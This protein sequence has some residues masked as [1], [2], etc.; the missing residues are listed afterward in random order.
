MFLFSL[1]LVTAVAADNQYKPYLHEASVPEH[2]KVKLYGSY[3]TNLFPGA[4]TYDY[5]IELPSGTGGLAPRLSLSYNSQTVAQRPGVM[6]AGWKLSQD[7]VY[8]DI[9]STPADPSDDSYKLAVGG[10]TYDLVFVPSDGFYHTKV[11]SFVRVEMPTGAGNTYGA[12]WLVTMRDGTKYRFG[13][14]NDSETVSNTGRGYAL[15]WSLDQVED[16]HGNRIFYTYL[17]DPNPEDAGSSYLSRI[18]YNNDRARSIRFDYEPLPRPDLR[19]AYESGNLVTESR[20]LTGISVFANNGLV[21]RYAIDYAALNPEGSLTSVS[22]ISY[23]G[24]DGASMLGKASFDYYQSAPG[25]TLQASQWTSPTSFAFE[26]ND[27]GVRYVDL[28]RDGFVDVVEYRQRTGE[29]KVWLNDGRGGWTDGTSVWALPVFTSAYDPS[30]SKSYY[31]YTQFASIEPGDYGGLLW[32][33]CPTTYGGDTVDNCDIIQYSGDYPTSTTIAPGESWVKCYPGDLS[34]ILYSMCCNGTSMISPSSHDAF[35]CCYGK[36]T[37]MDNGYP[38]CNG[39]TNHL[40]PYVSGTF[41]V[42]KTFFKAVYKMVDIDNGVRFADLNNDGLPDMLQSIDGTHRAWL[43][44]GSGWTEAPGQWAP[45]V[46][47]FSSYKDQG[48]QLTDLNGD[49]RVDIIQATDDAS[50]NPTRR[51]WLNTGSGWVDASATWAAPAA[52]VR[53]GKDGGARLEDVNGDGLPDILLSNGTGT[54]AWL[55]TGSGWVDAPTWYPPSASTFITSSS[56]DGGVRFADVNG[57]GL[58]DMLEDY[59]NGT[60]TDRGA[61]INSGHGWTLDPAWQS[62]EPFTKDGKNIGRRLADIDG[63]GQAD[64]SVAYSNSTGSYTW[65]WLRDQQTPFMLMRVTNMLGGTTQVGYSPSTSFPNYGADGLSD[66]GFNVWVVGNATSDNSVPGGFHVSSQTAYA[67][68]DGLYDYKDF[69]F[70]G[71]G[72]V[73]ENL[74]DGSY[75]VHYFHQ[76]DERKGI[77]YRTELSD[78]A[79]AL[80]SRSESEFDV[81]KMKGL[82][83]RPDPEPPKGTSIRYSADQTV[84]GNMAEYDNVTCDA[85]VTLTVCPYDGTAGTGYWNVSARYV[86]LSC[87]I[88][89]A[90]KGYTG[91]AGVTVGTG[92]NGLGQANG[93]GKG[94]GGQ[95]SYRG[96]GGGGGAYGGSGGTGDVESAR[97]GG[98]AGGTSFSSATA[99]QAV[100]MGSGGG[101]GGGGGTGCGGGAGG[102]G[103]AMLEI[104]APAGFVK[105]SGTINLNGADG[106]GGNGYSA[107]CLGWGGSGGAGSGGGLLLFSKTLDMDGAVITLSGGDSVGVANGGDPNGWGHAGGSGGGGRAYFIYTTLA[108]NASSINVNSGYSTGPQSLGSAG[109]AYFEENGPVWTD[110]PYS[111]PIETGVYEVL[112]SSRTDY[113]FDG[114]ADGPVTTKA[115]YSYD[116]YGNVVERR[117]LGDVSVAGDEKTERYSYATN[118]SAWIVNLPAEYQLL[119][120]DGTKAKGMSYAYDGL[121][122]GGGVAKGDLTQTKAWLDTAADESQNPVTSYA[123]DS[124]GNMVSSTDPLGRTTTYSYGE[125]DA[126]YTYPDSATNALGQ[127]TESAY[128]FGTGNLLWTKFSG[129]NRTYEYDVFGRVL[130]EVLPPNTDAAPTKFYSYSFDGSA[131]ELVKV[132]VVLPDGMPFEN[133]YFYDGF[134]T[135]V[136]VR[137]PANGGQQDV[138][139]VFYDGLGR[140]AKMQNPYFEAASAEL[141]APQTDVTYAYYTSYTY[142]PL[143]RAVKVTGPDATTRNVTF[144]RNTV[145]DYDQNGHRHTYVLDGYGRIAKVVEYNDDPLAG[146][147]GESESYETTY[148]YDTADN[149]VKIVDSASSTYAFAYDSLG[150]KI[151]TTDPDIGIVNY[152]YDLAGNLVSQAQAGGGSLVSGDGLYREYD[153]LNQLVRIRSGTTASSPLLENYTYDPYGSRVKIERNDSAKTKIY[154]PFREF[155]RIVNTTSTYDYTY[156]YQGD[157]LIARVNPDGSKYYYQSDSLGSTSLVTDDSGVVIENTFYSPYGEVLS[158]GKSDV[159]LYT[160]Q[161][162]DSASQYY[163]GARYYSPAVSQFTQPDTTVS[164]IY[165]PQSINPYSYAL[166]N[167]YRYTD[168]TGRLPVAVAF[169]IAMG[170][171]YFAEAISFLAMNPD[172]MTTSTVLNA[173]KYDSTDEFAPLKAAGDTV[174]E[175]TLFSAVNDLVVVPAYKIIQSY[176]LTKVGESP[177]LSN[178]I[179]REILLPEPVFSDTSAA[180]E[181][182]HTIDWINT[183]GP[184]KEKSIFIAGEGGQKFVSEVY[185][186]ATKAIVQSNKLIRL[187]VNLERPIGTRFGSIETGGRVVYDAITGIVK[188][189]F[190]QP[191]M[192]QGKSLLKRIFD[193]MKGG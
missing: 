170:V 71:F 78:G 168:P 117:M 169:A 101:A 157:N 22:G 74:P 31:E 181:L 83:K 152:T 66:L 160:G 131:P 109:T 161:F 113:L 36:V 102:N 49:G 20:R 108:A 21:R 65:T 17:E 172:I 5:P 154:T 129:V 10:T 55:N 32:V 189:D 149:L 100:A 81:T 112:L 124:Y 57:D 111:I 1:F 16:T 191:A 134:G 76:D 179:G 86:N 171:S 8:R 79:G 177:I 47:F 62:P 68:A 94:G 6:G 144:D 70:R 126:T 80:Y 150:R 46:D 165:N 12:Y 7:Y 107:S 97:C 54:R 182:R 174:L 15:K 93:Y 61:W 44:T 143:G 121:P 187:E 186:K 135:M 105:I 193:F 139:N 153:A 163:Y 84:C 125:R 114:H 50:G 188:T 89:G 156:V 119:G 104:N 133:Y 192:S 27:L 28:N 34:R 136:Q 123:Y 130:K 73:R 35:D 23:F 140:V 137:S 25:Y 183:G 151:F 64:I 53:D 90:G 18:D 145:D 142:D 67:Y 58:V 167:P 42:P 3:S 30:K 4:A 2:P 9:N 11:E 98:G 166:N 116:S 87:N 39:E 122:F 88:Y 99:Y 56:R 141:V 92:G 158:G 115:M 106:V 43:N 19:S 173:E 127:T 24:S 72:N 91:G 59:A 69:E 128:D 77:E 180:H 14:N 95:S 103:G 132:S 38:I 147:Y 118:P 176:V 138:S 155:M 178:A 52:F 48:V 185:E 184:F 29:N 75:A 33:D 63:D 159:K 190:P 148:S 26:D 60:T 41:N 85:G 110:D 40:Y 175:F 120:A 51:A 162:A 82:P 37:Y 13:Y 96:C 146:N 164:Q 45:P